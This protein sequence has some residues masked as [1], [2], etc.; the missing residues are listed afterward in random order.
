[1]KKY[2]FLTMNIGGINGAEQ[3]ILNKYNY[4]KDREDGYRVFIFSGRDSEILI[5]AF[6]PFRKL[7]HP[8]LRFYPSYLNAKERK[9]FTDWMLR[10]LDVQP[11]DTFVVE[12]SNITC[13]LWGEVLA[14]KLHCRH[15]AYIMQEN[16]RFSEPIKRFLRFKVDRHELAG[17]KAGSVQKMLGALAPEEREDMS[18]RAFCNNVVQDCEDPYSARFDPEPRI[19]IGSVGRLEKKHVLPLIDDL[20]AYFQ[21]H[22]DRKYRLV[23]IG[24]CADKR[25]TKAIEERIAQCPNVALLLTG[26][27]YPIP[28][29]LVN[30]CDLFISAAGS[31]AATYY[32]NRPT[33]KVSFDTGKPLGLMGYDYFVGVSGQE[34]KPTPLGDYIDMA[35]TKSVGIRYV[36]D[37]EQTYARRMQTEFERH[38]AIAAEEQTSAYYDV[39][40]IGYDDPK[41]KL[42]AY[43]SRVFGVRAA[44][45]TV[46]AVR[47]S[48]RE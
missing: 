6:E 34:E 38:L 11:D 7:I 15:F 22:A 44:Y 21:A 3:Y 35:L 36:E 40:N 32:A 33:I 12:S 1:M 24:G 23:L 46:E 31:A 37:Y 2:V 26:T 20:C 17:I 39:W 13:A 48:V 14:E 47:K 41:Y 27:V 43:I 45:R 8:A 4:L 25:Q 16:F 28:R 30:A 29:G 19:T 18:V 5:R 9:A 42:C 10:E